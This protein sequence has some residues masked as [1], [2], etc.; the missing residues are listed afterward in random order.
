MI[1]VAVPELEVGILT[2]SP[3]TNFAPPAVAVVTVLAGVVVFV[4]PESFVHPVIRT[5]EIRRNTRQDITRVF[6]FIVV[7]EP[8]DYFKKSFYSIRVFQYPR[9]GPGSWIS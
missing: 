5:L 6:L 1:S 7:T 8:G 2:I 3:D 9:S 4:G